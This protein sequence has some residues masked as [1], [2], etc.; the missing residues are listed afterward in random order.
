MKAADRMKNFRVR[1]R[2]GLRVVRVQYPDALPLAL[3]DSGFIEDWDTEDSAAIARAIERV[4]AAM[5]VSA[6]YDVTGS[7][8]GTV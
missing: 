8:D 6:G 4:L 2:N 3:A 7:D 5:V 1:R